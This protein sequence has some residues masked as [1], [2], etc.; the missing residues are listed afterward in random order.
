MKTITNYQ[1]L[2]AT[3][4]FILT[5]IF[6]TALYTSVLSGRY[7]TIGKASIIFFLLLF[8][9]SLI[10]GSR[11]KEPISKGKLGFKY[12][13]IIYL[14]VNLINTPSILILLGVSSENVII[15]AIQIVAWGVGVFFHW[16]FTYYKL[17]LIKIT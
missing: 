7:D 13:L 17:K 15:S 2:L 4:T 11:D 3:I 16:L 9:S 1:F 14:V 12:H 8:L 5:I 6:C 10:I